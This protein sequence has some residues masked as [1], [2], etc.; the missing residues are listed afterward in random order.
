MK[1]EKDVKREVRKIL[2]RNKWFCWMPPANAYGQAGAADFNAIKG[3]IFMAV[4]T[5]FGNNKPTALQDRFLVQI[6]IHGGISVVVNESNLDEFADL[7]Q[8][9][10]VFEMR[11]RMVWNSD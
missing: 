1:N 7:A 10:T 3:G 4:E 9:E 2:D 6:K 8:C 11:C 5:K